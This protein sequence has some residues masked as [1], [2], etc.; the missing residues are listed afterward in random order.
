MTVQLINIL[1][2]ARPDAAMGRIYLPQDEMVELGVIESDV[3][4]CRC[5]PAYCAL[6]A[7]TAE[8]A[9]TFLT[10]AERGGRLLPGVG[11]LFVAI[12]VE[13]Y[14][15]YLTELAR[16]GHDNLSAGGE[17]V[18]ISGPRKALATLRALLKLSRPSSAA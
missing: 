3:L 9:E 1:R 14:R 4:A 13:L 12:I 11:S 5:T 18:S 10:Q 7:R 8:R 6:V 15:D 2:D 16:R 17:R